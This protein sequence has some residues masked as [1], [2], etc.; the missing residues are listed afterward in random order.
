[1][2]VARE[3]ISIINDATLS[4][5]EK[6]ERVLEILGR[7]GGFAVDLSIMDVGA[8]VIDVYKD[9]IRV[10]LI[11]RRFGKTLVV[12]IREEKVVET[13]WTHRFP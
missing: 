2:S 12:T 6:I 5:R 7:L 9:E 13:W 8:V 11:F 3:I 10:G 4:G 1:M